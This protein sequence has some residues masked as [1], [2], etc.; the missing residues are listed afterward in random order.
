MLTAMDRGGVDHAVLLGWY[1]ENHATCVWHNRF[2]ADCVRRHPDRFTAFASVQP[3]AGQ[4]A[5][6]A[7]QEALDSGCR[8]LGELFPVAQGYAWEDPVFQTLLTWAGEQNWPVLLHAQNPLGPRHPGWI[9]AP[10]EPYVRLAGEFPQTTFIFAHWGGLL[11]FAEINAA[12]GKQLAN[13]YYDTAASPLLYDDRIYRA[14][15]N[16]IGAERILFGTDY[17]LRVYPRSEDV[18]CWLRRL[19]A[20]HNAGLSSAEEAAILGGN[21]SRIL[22]R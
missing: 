17:P 8:G 18:P 5:L 15:I 6:D 21:A 9:D 10:L 20:I 1:W 22:G 13:V 11:P 16:V 19:E 12:I 2:M 14:A 7:C 4:A 3:K